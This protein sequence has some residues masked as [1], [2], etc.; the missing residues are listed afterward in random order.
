MILAF[1]VVR[2]WV[3]DRR[4]APVAWLVLLCA[5]QSLII[6][7]GQ[8]FGVAAARWVQPVT[9]AM[10]APAAWVV[11]LASARRTLRAADLVH[12]SGPVAALVA[13]LAAPAM[14]DALLPLLFAGYGAGILWFGLRG[15][16]ALP[17]HRLNAGDLPSRLWLVIAATLIAS[18]FADLV[19]IAAQIAGLA[20]WQPWIITLFSGI[21]LLLIGGLGLS[22]ALES[23]PSDPEPDTPAAPSP[24]DADLMARLDAL[25]EAER[26]YLDPDLTLARLA[27]R[28]HVPVK[29]LSTAINRSTGDN[30][31]RYVN[32]ARVAA[33]Q[34]ALRSG[35]SVTGAMLT[36]G[37]GTKSNFNREF[38]RVTGQSPSA[39]RAAL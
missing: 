36:A 28:L 25:M 10:V 16:D 15:A 31:S 33:A 12:L 26:P 22:R 27:R 39:W 8:H 4:M 20:A 23:G 5:A 38:L 30:V 24:E 13:R 17:Q 9:A 1:L 7:L 21:N 29:Q 6:A 35:E 3:T 2:L 32:A 18:A 14:L 34:T 11:F 37:F 19:I